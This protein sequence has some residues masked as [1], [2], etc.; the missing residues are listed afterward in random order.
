MFILPYNLPS[1]R[2]SAANSV[3]K[4][5][6]DLV[7]CEFVMPVDVHEGSS[8]WSKITPISHS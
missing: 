2:Q 5:R 4:G 1:S 3:L 7:V 8:I 6:I